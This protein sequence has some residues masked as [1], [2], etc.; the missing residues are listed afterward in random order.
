MATRVMILVFIP[1]LAALFGLF[2][3]R[4]KKRPPCISDSSRSEGKR[5]HDLG[6][7]ST[8]SD[9][10]DISNSLGDTPVAERPIESVEVSSTK[11]EAAAVVRETHC[12]EVASPQKR[13]SDSNSKKQQSTRKRQIL[14]DAVPQTNGLE[15]DIAETAVEE[16]V[17]PP[18][19]VEELNSSRVCHQMAAQSSDEADLDNE[20]V[21]QPGSPN[22]EAEVSE[23][24][25]RAA[26]NGNAA[27]S[28][29]TTP[30]V[31]SPVEKTSLSGSNGFSSDAHSEVS[32]A[33]SPAVFW[34]C[35][36]TVS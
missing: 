15:K 28:G 6:T 32:A 13:V 27:S 11:P 18:I 14:A 24:T 21:S 20:S 3:F 36:C 8:V 34:Y 2:W 26:A 23:V 1:T 35:N 17:A 25:S 4:R 31:D 10:I 29:S 12:R 16:L 7:D 22:V 30:S 19:N 33:N 5:S 9:K